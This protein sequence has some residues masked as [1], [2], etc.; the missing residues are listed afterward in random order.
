[1]ASSAPPPAASPGG[2]GGAVAPGN[3]GSSLSSSP[4]SSS[5]NS[6]Q[7]SVPASALVAACVAAV[8]LGSGYI[9]WLVCR[10][11]ADREIAA[12]AAELAVATD[13][14]AAQSSGVAERTSAA[15]G[16]IEGFE[17]PTAPQSLP[18]GWMKPKHEKAGTCC[19]VVLAATLPYTMQPNDDACPE[20]LLTS[21]AVYAA[22]SLRQMIHDVLRSREVA[23]TLSNSPRRCCCWW[24]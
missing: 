14:L 20:M 8:A 10:R 22:P 17:P 2:G 9:G 23:G 6:V 4:S 3:A 18:N 15:L 16:A 24:W 7:L 19:N 21:C 12:L 11:Q 13:S 1:M 5:G